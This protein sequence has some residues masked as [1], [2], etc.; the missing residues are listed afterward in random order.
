M[1][2]KHPSWLNVTGG[3]SKERSLLISNRLSALMYEALD[4]TQTASIMTFI[5]GTSKDRLLKEVIS[6]GT[7]EAAASL[8]NLHV[9]K[10]TGR[11]NP[12]VLLANCLLPTDPRLGHQQHF[13]TARCHRVVRKTIPEDR[14]NILVSILSRILGPLSDILCL[15]SQDFGGFQGVIEFLKLWTVGGRGSSSLSIAPSLVIIIEGDQLHPQWDPAVERMF[16][17]GIPGCADLFDTLNVLRVPTGY[18]QLMKH[19]GPIFE[20]K[21]TARKMGNCLFSILHLSA[22]FNEACSHWIQKPHSPFD[23]IQATRILSPVPSDPSEHFNRALSLLGRD[24]G[25]ELIASSLLVDNLSPRMHCT[26]APT[27]PRT[28]Y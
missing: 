5:G 26:D 22:F 21:R 15:S 12:P 3:S 23:F 11:R 19:L 2:C 9:A 20:K 27:H 17:K 7:P 13:T 8:C 28:D 1:A 6:P 16:L 24:V 18:H 10:A 14:K 25:L 4:P